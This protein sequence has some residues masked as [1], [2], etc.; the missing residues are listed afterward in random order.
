M[1]TRRLIGYDERFTDPF[2]RAFTPSVQYTLG[3]EE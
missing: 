1:R 3:G 2:V